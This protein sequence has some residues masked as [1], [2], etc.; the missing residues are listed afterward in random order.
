MEE[1]NYEDELSEM[2]LEYIDEIVVQHTPYAKD[3][4]KRVSSVSFNNSSQ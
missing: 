2:A 1:L 3:K 4:T